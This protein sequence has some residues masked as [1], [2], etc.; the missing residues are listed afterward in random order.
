[1]VGMLLLLDFSGLKPYGSTGLG[2]LLKD[3][4]GTP[5]FIAS[6]LDFVTEH[7]SP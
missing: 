7:V 2:C 4:H 1:M 3:C 6:G 5:D